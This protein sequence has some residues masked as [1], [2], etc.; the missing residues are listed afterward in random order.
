MKSVESQRK[1][2]LVWQDNQTRYWADVKIQRMSS[3]T[4]FSM[5]KTCRLCAVLRFYNENPLLLD[6]CKIGTVY[7]GLNGLLTTKQRWLVTNHLFWQRSRR[8]KN[9]FFKIIIHISHIKRLMIPMVNVT[10]LKPSVYATLY[11][12]FTINEH[13]IPKWKIWICLVFNSL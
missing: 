8:G 2:K 5:N 9:W 3:N 4:H 12:S 7:C 13:G 10:L 6:K 11:H 1:G